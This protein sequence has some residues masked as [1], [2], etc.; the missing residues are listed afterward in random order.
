MPR[1]FG[2]NHLALG[3]F[4]LT[5]KTTKRTQGTPI[6]IYYVSK[7]K[8]Q[9]LGDLKEAVFRKTQTNKNKNKK[10]QLYKPKKC[11]HEERGY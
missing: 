10:E 1:K 2:D 5:A 9:A 7:L 8:V 4:R 6:E 3:V 11:N